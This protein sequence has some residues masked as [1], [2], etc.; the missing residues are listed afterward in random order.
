MI[1][2][3]IRLREGIASALLEV[4]GHEVDTSD[5]ILSETKK[6][7]VGDYTVVVFPFT[8]AL[9]QKPQDIANTIGNWMMANRGGVI[10]DFS[11]IKGFLNF[12]L[13]S[14]FWHESLK[15]LR[16]SANLGIEKSGTS[17]VLVEYSS[18]NTN[19]PLHLGHVRNILLG[20][21]TQKILN[22]VGHDV[23]KT[24]VINDRGIAICKSML[25]WK[26]DSDRKT[27]ETAGMK[28]D[29][30]VGHY[31]VQF[32]KLFQREYKQWQESTEGITE[33]E[34]RKDKDQD[35]NVFFRSYKN[36]YFNSKSQIG[37]EARDMLLAWEAEDTDVRELWNKMNGW[38]YAGWEDTYA[39]LGVSFDDRDY[40]SK[41]YLLGKEIIQQGLESGAFFRKDDGSVWVDLEDQGL[42]QKILLRSDGTSVYMTQD[43]GTAN[44]RYEKFGADKMIYVVGDEQDYHFQVLFEILRQLKEPY[45]DGLYHLSY[46]MVDLPS[47]KMKGREGTIVDA[48]DLISEVVSEV[49]SSAKER[50]ELEDLS[51]EERQE[52][53]RKIGMSAL[54]FFIL[55][56]NPKKRMVFNP[57]ESVDIQGQTGPYIQNA[58]VRIQSI[59]RKLT[60]S[61]NEYYNE[62]LELDPSEKD[63][64]Q[65]LLNYPADVRK[66]ANNYDPSIIANFAYDLA[67]KF[68][69]F[70]H[71][72]RVL[73][74]ETPDARS[75]RIALSDQVAKT[76]A[77]AM[78][79]LGIEMPERM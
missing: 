79:L 28:G 6:E 66:A 49:E 70:Y 75:F 72:V 38:V 65:T 9:R 20:W 18:P 60:E 47:G 43:L 4:Y 67:K 7:F 21:S 30:L 71:D 19:K 37:R 23:T 56:I 63:L 16:E 73:T 78:D 58:Y 5:L 76:L 14:G 53:Y 69:K 33:F 15:K 52:I 2:Y 77:H 44:M 11:V 24:K 50:G 45:A 36:E 42:D 12:V 1:D 13:P 54:K 41:T 61:G 62:Y 27:P 55:K 51:S 48:D 64:I 31:Y 68:H 39:K 8:K 74:A 3:L 26:V 22:A 59:R 40:E 57:R 25:A 35:T 10:S 29:H 17:K 32:E 34:N 46:G